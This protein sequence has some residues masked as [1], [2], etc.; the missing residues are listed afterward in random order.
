MRD[1]RLLLSSSRVVIAEICEV[2]LAFDGYRDVG[3]DRGG[4]QVEI[5]AVVVAVVIVEVERGPFLHASA[6]G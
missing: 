1:F 6:C 4:C 3:A 5:F 2:D